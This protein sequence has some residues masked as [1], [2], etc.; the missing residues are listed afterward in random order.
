MDIKR[1]IDIISH[2]RHDFLNHLAVIS[3]LV[4][5]NKLESVPGYIARVSQEIKSVGKVMH[6]VYHRTALTL[7]DGY[8]QAAG[9]HV[10]LVFSLDWDFS[11]CRV[12]DD[13]VARVV[14]QGLKQVLVALSTSRTEQLKME[15]LLE[16]TPSFGTIRLG[17]SCPEGQGGLV[18][19]VA[20]LNEELGPVGG[21]AGMSTRSGRTEITILL[22]RV[23]GEGETGA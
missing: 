1:T 16:Y 19:V 4:Q 23:T 22:P 7:M 18:E 15:L 10:E 9:C 12:P 11:G 2:Q 14:S 17:F 20:W 6:L 13:M 5:L 3:G 21:S 8:Y